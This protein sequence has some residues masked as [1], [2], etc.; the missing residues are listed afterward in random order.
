MNHPSLFSRAFLPFL[1]LAALL[2]AGAR[3]NAASTLSKALQGTYAITSTKLVI[4]GKLQSSGGSGSVK[5]G[6]SGLLIG[7]G[8]N[9]GAG[10]VATIAKDNGLI[11]KFTNVKDSVT[12]FSASF[13][14]TATQ[15]GKLSGTVSAT[16]KSS[17]LT[18]VFKLKGT[19]NGKPA[20]GS[21][22]VILKKKK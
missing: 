1:A 14:G 9:G 2:F 21:L 22:T 4:D 19:H 13:S 15:G 16:L 3:A 7:N 12:T 6:A 11:L 5:I 10:S 17:G 8:G 18:V 20:T